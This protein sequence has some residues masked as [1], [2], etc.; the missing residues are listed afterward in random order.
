MTFISLCSISAYFVLCIFML[1]FCIFTRIKIVN[2]GRAVF[3]NRV[4]WNFSKLCWRK[5]I[6]TKLRKHSVHCTT[7]IIEAYMLVSL[8]T[9]KKNIATRVNPLRLLVNVTVYT[10]SRM[11]YDST[12][13]ARFI[14]N[15]TKPPSCSHLVTRYELDL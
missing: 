2:N 4:A 13:T 8:H 1:H 5:N 15:T 9:P 7:I 14:T 6:M 3:T 12:N 10:V 11:Y